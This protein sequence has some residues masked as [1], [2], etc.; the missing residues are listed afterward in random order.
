MEKWINLENIPKRNGIRRYKNRVI[1]DWDNATNKLCNFCYNDFHGTLKIISYDSKTYS[2]VVEYEGNQYKIGVK[3]FIEASFKKILSDSS[4][5]NQSQKIK[6]AVMPIFKY[7]IGYHYCKDDIY[8]FKIIDREYYTKEVVKKSK[9]YL[10]NKNDIRYI[11]IIVDMN[12]GE[13]KV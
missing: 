6:N 2:L 11:A 13:M 7:D 9:T 4:L 1:Y 5:Y 12:Y 3:S 8:D 10:Y